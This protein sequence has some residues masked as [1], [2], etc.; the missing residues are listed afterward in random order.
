MDR[1]C[2]AY[3]TNGGGKGELVRQLVPSCHSRSIT[4]FTLHYFVCSRLGIGAPNSEY[5]AASLSKHHGYVVAQNIVDAAIGPEPDRG[6]QR[7]YQTG[8]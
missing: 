3:L 1:L 5:G 6:I 2:S 7:S 8:V 4:S